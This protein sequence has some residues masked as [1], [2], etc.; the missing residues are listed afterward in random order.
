TSSARARS[1]SI[2]SRKRSSDSEWRSCRR[3]SAS[4]SPRAQRR[5][6]TTSVGPGVVTPSKGPSQPDGGELRCSAPLSARSACPPDPAPPHSPAAGGGLHLRL[7]ITPHG[8]R[9][10][11]ILTIVCGLAAWGVALI[12]WPLVVL[13]VALWVFG[14]SFFRDPERRLPDDAALL[15][16]P[17]D[18]T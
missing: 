9:A 10:L 3:R 17:A 16:S 11:A 18:G 8:V 4:R 1:C 2:R 13:P 7:P 5:T 6:R 15:V 14:V 12:A